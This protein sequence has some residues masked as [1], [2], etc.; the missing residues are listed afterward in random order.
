MLPRIN[1]LSKKEGEIIFKKGKTLKTGFLLLKYVKNYKKNPFV[2]RLAIVVPAKVS[3][4]VVKRN[5]IKRQLRESLRRKLNF[6]K[7]EIDGLIIALPEIIDKNY[8]EIDKNLENLIKK[9]A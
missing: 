8:Q 1:R 6:I 3:K 9:I 7:K 4:K 5:K 2:P